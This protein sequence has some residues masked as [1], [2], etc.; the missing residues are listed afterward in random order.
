MYICEK[1]GKKVEQVF[2]SGRF[3]S[4]ACANSRQLS[5]ETKTKISTSLLNKNK[6]K[7]HKTKVYELKLKRYVRE[8]KVFAE[9]IGLKNSPYNEYNVASEVI[10]VEGRRAYLLSLYEGNSRIKHE[11]ILVHRYNMANKL[12]RKLRSDEVVHHIDG[13]KN[14]NSISNL[15]IMSV[16]E[17]SRLHAKED[18]NFAKHTQKNG[19]WN[20]GL[21][22]CYSEESLQKMRNSHTHKTQ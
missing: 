8:G 17:H 5:A 6:D 9:K 14:N 10:L 18:N 2:G 13:N 11:I 19:P 3:C 12:G 1:C 16:S 21:K 20:K 7:P 4:R 15:E 22:N